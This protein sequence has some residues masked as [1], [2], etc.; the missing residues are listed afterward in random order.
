MSRIV[1]DIVPERKK[2]VKMI[3]ALASNML[4]RA[5]NAMER[6]LRKR[7]GDFSGLINVIQTSSQ[8]SLESA[9]IRFPCI[10]NL[11]N[12]TGEDHSTAQ[13]L[14]Q[15]GQ[16]SK[17]ARTLES[18]PPATPSQETLEILQTLHPVPDTPVV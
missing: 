12:P 8:Q 4:F 5:P 11:L 1:Q 2:S 13:K 9:G 6:E 10:T 17:S 3:L 16:I 7:A 14:A 18:L 15:E